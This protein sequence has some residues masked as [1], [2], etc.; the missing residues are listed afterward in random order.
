MKVTPRSPRM[1]TACSYLFPSRVR[2]STQD[3]SAVKGCFV[4][5]WIVL[6]SL[7]SSVLVFQMSL[8]ERGLYNFLCEIHK[9]HK[10]KWACSPTKAF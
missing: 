6:D 1:L 8:E 2:P 5:L 7:D 9:S 4:L 10:P 3:W